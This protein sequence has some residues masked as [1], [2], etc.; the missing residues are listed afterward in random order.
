MISFIDDQHF[1][2]RL[3]RQTFR[4]NSAGEPGSYY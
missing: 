1:F 3:A 4:Q 2:V